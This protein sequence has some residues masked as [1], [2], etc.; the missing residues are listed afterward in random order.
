VSADS[1]NHLTFAWSLISPT[2]V[3]TIC[4]IKDNDMPIDGTPPS[5][6]EGP[7]GKD[8]NSV[9]ASGS[10]Y[11]EGDSNAFHNG[12]EDA[13]VRRGLGSNPMQKKLLSESEHRASD[14]D[15]RRLK[16]SN[17]GNEGNSINFVANNFQLEP[18]ARVVVTGNV[19][20]VSN[21]GNS[22]NYVGNTDGPEGL[23]A[24]LKL[25]ALVRGDPTQ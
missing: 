19:E 22:V 16:I 20:N 1:Q 6:T 8:H 24:F 10:R 9:L 3:S 4:G 13:P 2:V 14:D 18:S 15:V 5:S 7:G 11:G 21:G 12:G 17:V 25:V 23:E